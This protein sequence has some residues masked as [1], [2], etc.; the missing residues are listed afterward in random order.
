MRK[1]SLSIV[2]FFLC[3]VLSDVF[4]QTKVDWRQIKNTPTTVSGYGITDTVSIDSLNSAVE[5]I[6]ENIASL[7]TIIASDTLEILRGEIPTNASFTFQGLSEIEGAV[8]S[9]NLADNSVSYE[10]LDISLQQTI[11][12]ANAGIPDNSIVGSKLA[13]QTVTHDYLGYG[14]VLNDNI[15]Q[16]EVNSN[17]IENYSVDSIDL[18]TASVDT[19]ILKDLSVTNDKIANLAVTNSKIDLDAISLDNMSANSVGSGQIIDKNVTEVKLAN[20]AVV[21]RVIASNSV[22]VDKIKDGEITP[23]KLNTLVSWSFDVLAVSTL[24]S[25]I[26]NLA[27]LT[28]LPTSLAGALVF[29]NDNLY[30]K[31]SGYWDKLLAESDVSIPNNASFTLAGLGEKDF[32]S[33]TNRPTTLSGYGITDAA[34]TY[35]STIETTYGLGTTANYGHVRTINALTQGSHA[36]GTALSAYQGYVLNNA[37]GAKLDKAGGT[38]NGNLTVLGD[39]TGTVSTATTALNALTAD[40][41]T[42]AGSSV[43]SNNSDFATYAEAAHT[44]IASSTQLSDTLPIAFESPA[45]PNS[46]SSYSGFYSPTDSTIVMRTGQDSYKFEYNQVTLGE[47]V[48][49]IGRS[50]D[51]DEPGIPNPLYISGSNTSLTGGNIALGGYNNPYLSLRLKNKSLLYLSDGDIYPVRIASHTHIQGRLETSD[52][53][54]A[55]ALY[56]NS[57]QTK[58]MTL[59]PV[60]RSSLPASMPSSGVMYFDYDDS[61]FYGRVNNSWEILNSSNSDFTLA[62]LSEKSYNSL[63]DKPTVGL[64]FLKTLIDSFSCAE[65]ASYPALVSAPVLRLITMPSELTTPHIFEWI[66]ASYSVGSDTYTDGPVHGKG[67]FVFSG[68]TMMPNGK[69]MLVPLYSTTI[70]IYDPVEDTYTNGPLHGKGTAAFNYSAMMPNGKV[71]LLPSR[72]TNIGIYDPVEDTYTDG[73]LHGKGWDA[74]KDCTLM[75]NGKVMLTPFGSANIGIYDPVTNTYTDGPTHGRGPQAFIGCAMMPNGKVMLAPSRLTNIGIYDP[76]TNTYTNGPAHEKGTDAFI[77]CAM[78]PNGKVMLVPYQSATIG[79]YDPVED[80]YTDGP[81]HGKG[82]GAFRGSTLLPNGKVMLVPH[83]SA[84]IGIYDPTTDTYTD[85]PA[86]G[87]GDYAFLGSTLMPNGKV[88]LT[89]YHSPNIGIYDPDIIGLELRDWPLLSAY[90]NKY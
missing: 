31:K 8:G 67:N 64:D 54:T 48:T 27:N 36:D 35:H 40:Y 50:A 38:I 39:I 15:G 5:E 75:P 68:C 51:A 56:G 80:T 18:A 57:A 29:M 78:M 14:S 24:N 2:L 60:A 49:F 11:D 42:E 1:H 28:E 25:G 58:R 22:T 17:S 46:P 10:T 47:D 52:F 23:S 81:T 32:G 83:Q 9:E 26:I 73:P 7:S 69:V 19:R 63:T 72:S 44:I 55:D 21:E 20:N 4:S 37:V 33:L 76:V 82:T 65:F 90:F 88:M 3:L 85:G 53:I 34:P 41:A 59:T 12:T 62:G 87:K 61:K 13:T 45:H 84:N 86:H 79:I 43:S 66:N 70:G 6:N 77:G 71:M 89:P 74:F 16:G 30:I